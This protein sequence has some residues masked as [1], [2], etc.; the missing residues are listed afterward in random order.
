MK[1]KEIKTPSQLYGSIQIFLIFTFVL[2]L[3]G[4]VIAQVCAVLYGTVWSSVVLGVTLSLTSWMLEQAYNLA[5]RL[6]TM[7]EQNHTQPK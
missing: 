5:A 3:F 2:S 1:E 6:A 4:V 7:A